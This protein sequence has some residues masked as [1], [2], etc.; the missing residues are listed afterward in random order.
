MSKHDARTLQEQERANRAYA[1]VRARA[2]GPADAWRLFRT[3]A[4]KLPVMVHNEGA[5]RALH[6]VAA[7]G[8][9]HQRVLLD[10]LATALGLGTRAKL[11]EHL[12]SL[13]PDALREATR[14]IQ[15]QLGWYKR[16]V[17]AFGKDGDDPGVTP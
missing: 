5:L 6:F 3:M 4:L 11:L 14:T 15:R 2:Q 16:M 1:H 8:Q 12:R 10:D 13:D 9:D 7:R 17:Q